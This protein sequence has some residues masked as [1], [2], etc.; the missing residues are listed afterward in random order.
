VQQAVQHRWK[1]CW[2]T[3]HP[4][5]GLL[6]TGPPSPR[7]VKLHKGLRKA[8]SSVITQ[9]RTGRIGLAAFLNKARVPGFPSPVCAC[10]QARETAAHVI[11]HCSRFAEVRGRLADPQSDRLDVRAL[12]SKV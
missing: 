12:V 7:V 2:E 1:Q 11:A 8:E 9:I 5:W 6:D 3:R 10:G 4:E